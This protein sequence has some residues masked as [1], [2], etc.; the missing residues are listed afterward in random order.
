MD[1]DAVQRESV[2]AE[3]PPKKKWFN[4]Q[5]LS[6]ARKVEFRILSVLTAH[7]EVK[8]EHFQTSIDE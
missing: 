6:H 4:S 7:E 1:V 3:M 5:I 2:V 8:R